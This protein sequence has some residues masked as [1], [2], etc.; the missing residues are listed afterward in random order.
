MKFESIV[1]LFV[2]NDEMYSEYRRRMTPLLESYDGGFRYDF[3]VAKVLINESGDPINRVFAIYFGDRERMDRF[4]ADPDYLRVK[5]KY[6][7][8]SVES[9]TIISA[10]EN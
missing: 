5:E 9:V 7:S 10:Y 4:F 3:C 8:P 6:F 2:T 1:G